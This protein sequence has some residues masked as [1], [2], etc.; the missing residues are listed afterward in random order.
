[1][2]AMKHILRGAE[3]ACCLNLAA[4]FN[5]GETKWTY[6]ND[7]ENIGLNNANCVPVL[8]ILEKYG[9]IE[10]ITDSHKCRFHK[11]TV[12]P[13]VVEVMRH[14]EEQAAQNASGDDIVAQTIDAMRRHRVLA[15]LTFAVIGLTVFLSIISSILTILEK[16][17][18]L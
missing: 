13:G 9:L 1:V 18:L 4:R 14:L 8:S 15:W 5:R 16:L 11:F 10:E 6:A 2:Q 17:G 7:W 3:L 12:K